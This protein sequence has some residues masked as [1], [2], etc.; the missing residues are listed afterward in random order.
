M[1]E[2][3]DIVAH[4]LFKIAELKTCEKLVLT[5]IQNVLHLNG[6]KIESLK[7]VPNVIDRLLVSENVC[8]KINLTTPWFRENK[9]KM[10]GACENR[11]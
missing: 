11:M 1:I 6:L 8:S 5:D 4:Q 10:N 7:F 2:W 3:F 9:S